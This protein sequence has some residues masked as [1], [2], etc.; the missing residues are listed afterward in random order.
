[1]PVMTEPSGIETF[2]SGVWRFLLILSPVI[3]KLGNSGIRLTLNIGH[4]PQCVQEMRR[5]VECRKLA[6]I[7]NAEAEVE[8]L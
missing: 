3:S 7:L 8:S 2:E 4:F 1:M 5:L 6:K